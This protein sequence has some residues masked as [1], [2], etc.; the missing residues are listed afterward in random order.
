MPDVHDPPGVPP[1]FSDP[2]GVPPNYSDPP[3]PD[4]PPTYTVSVSLRMR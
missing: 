1:N 2:P 4:V 3:A